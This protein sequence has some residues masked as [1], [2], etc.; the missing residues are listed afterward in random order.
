MAPEILKKSGYGEKCD[1]WS[2]GVIVFILLMGYQPFLDNDQ[3]SVDVLIKSGKYH[4]EENQWA[5]LSE[6]AKD[7][8][9]KLLCVDAKDRLSATEALRHPWI[10]N[11]KANNDS[12]DD[13]IVSSLKSYARA[14]H[15]RR[16]CMSMMAWSL[17]NK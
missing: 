14:S 4:K 5:R 2:M 7:F 16:A 8:I 12:V 10:E 11:R 1:L 17:T 6:N 15:F 3:G 13:S 9:S